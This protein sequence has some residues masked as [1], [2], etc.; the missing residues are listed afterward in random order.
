MAVWNY[1][2]YNRVKAVLFGKSFIFFSLGWNIGIL[3][4]FE[5]EKKFK[6]VVIVN[7][8]PI[9]LERFHPLS[10]YHLVHVFKLWEFYFFD[11]AISSTWF[12]Y[13]YG[14]G[15]CMHA[16]SSIKVFRKNSEKFQKIGGGVRPASHNPYPIMHQNQW[17]Y[18]LTLES[19]SCFRLE[20]Q[21]VS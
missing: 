8:P 10:S 11:R 12:N 9:L 7:Q 19:K 5:R 13:I 20:L 6:S 21:L 4:T 16:E 2:R 14:F 18:D 1:I 3:G 15:I 17:Y